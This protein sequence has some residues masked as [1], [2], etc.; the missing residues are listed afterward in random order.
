MATAI[1][2]AIK[3]AKAKKAVR[4]VEAKYQRVQRDFDKDPT[5]SNAKA[6]MEVLDECAEKHRELKEARS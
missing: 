5:P 2:R 6:L 1:E 3:I 4:D